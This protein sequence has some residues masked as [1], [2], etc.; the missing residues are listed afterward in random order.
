M[1]S[2]GVVYVDFGIGDVRGSYGRRSPNPDWD[3]N[4][5]Y[6]QLT[7][8]VN[9]GDGFANTSYFKSYGRILLSPDSFM[10][11]NY[12]SFYVMEDENMITY[13]IEYSYGCIISFVMEIPI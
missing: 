11:Y 3:D 13:A 8:A 7:G 10:Y 1:T 2:S 5:C 6:V 9:N 12:T 4:V